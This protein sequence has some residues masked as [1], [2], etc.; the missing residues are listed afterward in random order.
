MASA[1][2]VQCIETPQ[3]PAYV[4]DSAL[5]EVTLQ[6]IDIFRTSLPLNS[7]RPTVDRRFFA[8]GPDILHNISTNSSII[9]Q[10]HQN[11]A[12]S[13]T[14]PLHERSHLPH[15]LENPSRP[16]STL[17]ER[18]LQRTIS[19]SQPLSP[20]VHQHELINQHH[21]HPSFHV[22]QY[23]R[24]LEYMQ[25]GSKLDPHTDGTKVCDD[26]SLTSTHTLLLYLTT[27]ERGGETMLLTKKCSS[28]NSNTIDKHHQSSNKDQLSLKGED[29]T[30]I[31]NGSILLHA[32][33]PIRGRILLFPHAT[34]HAGAVVQSVPKICLR[35]E[36]CLSH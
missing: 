12:G 8:D 10:H 13:I 27:C 14:S 4:I 30:S 31:G 19:F 2:K 32:T 15:L 25:Q 26:T 34:L 5:D 3:G 36:V 22:F 1:A 18:T 21:Y 17:L 28:N 6:C 23:Q 29:S 35:A 20:S 16:I 11:T 24:F 7:K 33:Q 9:T